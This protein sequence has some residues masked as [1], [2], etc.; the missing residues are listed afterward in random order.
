MSTSTKYIIIGLLSFL[1]ISTL[2]AGTLPF[3]FRAGQPIK[4]DEVNAN[5]QALNDNKQS[6]ITG[7]PCQAGQFVTGLSTD[8]KLECGIDQIG[9]A[10]S[11]GVSSLN[12]KTGSLAIEG[13]NGVTVE[14]SEDGK[15]MI[16][17]STGG[18]ES[19]ATLT[20]P[21]SKTITNSNPAFALTNNGGIALSGSSPTGIGVYAFSGNTGYGVSAYSE[22]NYGVLA[23]TNTG[24][25]GV[26]GEGKINGGTG[27][28]GVNNAGPG[29]SGVWGESALGSGVRGGTTSGTGVL[30]NSNTGYGVR[31]VV[32]QSGTGVYG[33]NTSNTA[34]AGI[35]GRANNVNSVGVNGLSNNG[36]GVS[37]SSN[38]NKGVVGT[39]VSNTAGSTSIAVD[40]VNN[41]VAGY[42][43]RG[44]HK[45][46]GY[47]V[48]GT[49]PQV[50]VGG[51]SANIGVLGRGPTA[52]RAEGNAVQTLNS[53][54]WAKAMI[55]VRTTS[56]FLDIVRCF[57]S[58]ATGALVNSNGCGF[59]LTS[60]GAGGVNVDFGFDISQRFVGSTLHFSGWPAAD[61]R[62]LMMV[63]QAN[64]SNSSVYVSS[65]LSESGTGKYVNFTLIIF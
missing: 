64:L 8:S 13:G 40:G 4:A 35:Q 46:N 62:P 44:V 48:Y 33:E 34:G 60:E 61:D 7:E 11:S 36:T 23:Y 56:G 20:F 51:E 3:T 55:Y 63:D 2:A 39:I 31:G 28:R 43:V 27:V 18:I 38:T 1:G 50:G 52:M 65:W 58:Q 53:G 14:T 5:F 6:T 32:S 42:G 49:A 21:F 24:L 30:G 37:G 16:S 12:G 57:N 9:S 45:G 15:V 19:Q 17:S 47:G 25:A 41:G 10:G 22:K 29:S 59:T 54:G 26:Y